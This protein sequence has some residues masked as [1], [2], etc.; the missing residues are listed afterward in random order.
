MTLFKIIYRLVQICVIILVVS[1][2]I[3]DIKDQKEFKKM[4]DNELLS[5]YKASP[6]TTRFEEYKNEHLSQVQ[7][8][9]A[10]REGFDLKSSKRSTVELILLRLSFLVLALLLVHILFDVLS[11]PDRVKELER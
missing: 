7:S 11:L 9:I 8:S 1:F 5:S 2:T 6:D 10:T 4:V 3:S